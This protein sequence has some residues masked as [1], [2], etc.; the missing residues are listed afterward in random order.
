MLKCIRC[1]ACLNVCPVY[2]KTG[3]HAY[4]PVYSGPMGAVLAPLLAG[5]EN[6]PSLPHASSLC[7]ACTD[8]CPVKIPLHE[9]LLE[10]RRDLV[11]ERVA[12]LGERLAFT[13]WSY[14]WSSRVGFRLS[15]RVAR[16]FQPLGGVAG[17]GRAWSRGRKLPRLR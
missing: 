9:L 8:I 15:T 1:G 10:L 13:L 2:G 4:G 3:G 14:A 7:G 17:P 5:I 6:A 11:D 12:P 16:L